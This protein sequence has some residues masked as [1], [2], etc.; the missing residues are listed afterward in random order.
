M[1]SCIDVIFSCCQSETW[2]VLIL[3]TRWQIYNLQVTRSDVLLLDY[4]KPLGERIVRLHSYQNYNPFIRLL[5]LTN[6]GTVTNTIL[7][8]RPN[9]PSVSFLIAELQSIQTMR[10]RSSLL[11]LLIGVWL[12]SQVSLGQHQTLTYCTHCFTIVSIHSYISITIPSSQQVEEE[13]V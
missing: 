11:Q 12:I 5:E 13:I 9:L 6:V 8:D 3:P 1:P 7:Q 4:R 10:L 2:K